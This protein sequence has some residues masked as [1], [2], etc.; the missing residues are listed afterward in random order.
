MN[1]D[2]KRIKILEDLLRS[3]FPTPKNSCA[4]AI[5]DDN[6]RLIW[7]DDAIYDNN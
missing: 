7:D 3:F 6:F 5:E 4:P 1:S 2:I